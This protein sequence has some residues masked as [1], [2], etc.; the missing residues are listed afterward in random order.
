VDQGGQAGGED[1]PAELPSVPVHEVR[2]WLSV[3]AYSWGNL[4]R[5]LLLPNRI[6]K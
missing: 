5:R 4:L 6:E 2:P 1:D 3:L